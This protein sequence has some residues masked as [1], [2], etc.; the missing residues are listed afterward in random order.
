MRC[1]G[2]AAGC[3]WFAV[4]CAFMVAACRAA[5]PTLP[6]VWSFVV[7]CYAVPA[8]S[9]QLILSAGA[10]KIPNRPGNTGGG[11]NIFGHLQLCATISQDI[12]FCYLF[13]IFLNQRVPPF[14]LWFF[15]DSKVPGLFSVLKNS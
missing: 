6:C 13:V 8:I 2:D 9:W 12:D 15:G 10:P 14:S 4:L 11:N 5:Q 1:F 7:L 3:G